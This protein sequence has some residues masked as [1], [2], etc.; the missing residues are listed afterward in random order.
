MPKG[1]RTLA[2]LCILSACGGKASDD[3]AKWQ[4][5]PGAKSCGP[6]MVLKG[7]DCAAVVT[8]DQ[9]AAV[10]AAQAKVDDL[11]KMLDAVDAITAPV[12]LLDT[13]RALDEWKTLADH[14]DKLKAVDD[15]VAQLSAASAQVHALQTTLKSS[16]TRLQKLSSALTVITTNTGPARKLENVQQQVN[17]ALGGVVADLQPQVVAALAKVTPAL[18]AQ[19]DDISDALLGA[20]TFVKFL[21]G[22]KVKEVCGSARDTFKKAQRFVDDV[23]DRPAKVVG[24]VAQALTSQLGELSNAETQQIAKRAQD[25]VDAAIKARDAAKAAK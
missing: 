13:L 7:A 8:K 15:L 3:D 20:C 14:S 17:A 19:L 21:G 6:G 5:E 22:D 10:S 18:S 23:A 24:D 11:A 2:L 12:Q 4:P 9:V 1:M 16:S 25:A